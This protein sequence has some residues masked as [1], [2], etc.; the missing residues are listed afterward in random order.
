MKKLLLSIASISSALF[1]TCSPSQ[2]DSKSDAD[3]KAVYSTRISESE[4]AKHIKSDDQFLDFYKKNINDP[5]ALIDN[6]R[7]VSEDQRRYLLFPD[8]E[9]PLLVWSAKV[10]PE[11]VTFLLDEGADIN[12]QTNLGNTALMVAIRKENEELAEQL[13]K[14]GADTA[15]VNNA[16]ATA[17]NEVDDFINQYSSQ[18]IMR[19]KWIKEI[20]KLNRI[21]NMLIPKAP[22]APMP[23]DFSCQPERSATAGSI[24]SES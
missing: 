18:Q 21:R 14:R 10:R 4:I 2:G 8:K 5:N 7:D 1:L 6:S 16:G 24:R 11:L 15:I 3:K 19:S 9:W 13:L 22:P 20:E 12:K 23:T 17:L